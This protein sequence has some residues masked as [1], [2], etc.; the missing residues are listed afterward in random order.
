MKK[1]IYKALNF[2][3][4]KIKGSE[5]NLDKGIKLTSMLKLTLY[6]SVQPVRGFFLSLSLKKG[7]SNFIFVENNVHIQH[8]DFLKL[9]S[10]CQIKYGVRMD[11][12]SKK[13]VSI[14]KGSSIGEYG[15]LKVTGSISS[16][17]EG[18]KI[19]EKSSFDSN[20]FI[21]GS[22]GVVVG[23]NV[24]AGQKVSFHPENHNFSDPNKPIRSQGTSKKGIVI[25]DNCWIGSGVI[26]LDGSHISKGCVIGAGSVVRGFFEPNSILAGTPAKIV[27]STYK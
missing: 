1:I 23:N 10:G 22:G 17:G 26:F 27:K 3:F 11:C 7:S 14:G 8:S 25:E 12:L 16:L 5:F 2:I 4:R 21:G 9:G 19:G 24:I 20:V 6:R 15:I 13:G 18:I